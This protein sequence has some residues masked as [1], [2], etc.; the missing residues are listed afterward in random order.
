M[1]GFQMLFGA[2]SLG[3]IL[4]FGGVWMFQTY[5]VYRFDL[6]PQSPEAY[7]L[8]GVKVVGF[9]SEDGV[10]AQAWLAMPAPGQPILFSFYGNFSAYNWNYCCLIHD[11]LVTKL[12][13]IIKM[14][15]RV[16]VF[17]Y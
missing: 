6:S 9:T 7:G 3:L 14:E 4:L 5:G 16:S 8:T 11:I 15:A 12:H 1:T 10:P 13:T 2:I 17:V